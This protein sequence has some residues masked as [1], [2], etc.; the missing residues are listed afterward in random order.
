MTGTIFDI[1]RFA[2]H[3]GPGIRTTV[4]LKGCPL[5]CFWC[6][7][8][9]SQSPSPV[10]MQYP[11]QCIGCG[12]CL[13]VCPNGAL[14]QGEEQ[15]IIDRSR[16][17]VCGRCGAVCYAQALVLLGRQVTVEEV[18]AE[19]LKDRAFYQTSGGGMTLSGGEPMAQLA[20]ATALL[21][22]AKG[23]GLHN[24]LDTCGFARW[25]LYEAV[26]PHLDLV[27]YDLK[28][29]ESSAHK[30]AT[31]VDN[32]LILENL[33]RLSETG[34]EILVRVPVVPGLN[35]T[36]EGIA[37]LARLVAALPRPVPM[38]LLAYHRLGESKHTA[39]GHAPADLPDAPPEAE[40]MHDLVAA[41]EAAG[42]ECRYEG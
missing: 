36:P 32:A 17:Q 9:E 26:L 19:V 37:A 16:C 15:I 18:I 13:E 38:E 1:K 30:I 8:P 28:A 10:L 14:S 5:R 3:D 40:L 22:A 21:Q 35:A 4:F 34:V 7:N 29:G 42:A 12:R 6:H 39:M 20:F 25:E 23:E 11:S 31:G 41:A 2:I 27:L 24:V 33:Q